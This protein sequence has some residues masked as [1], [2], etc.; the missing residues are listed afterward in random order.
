MK[1]LLTS[2]G[3]TNKTIAD[4][5]GKLLGKSFAQAKLAFIPTAADISSGD[6]SW[7]INDLN[8]CKKLGFREIDI[9]DIAAVPQEKIWRPRI[10]SADVLLFGG[11]NTFFLMH[12]L[13]KSGLAKLLPELLKSKVYVGISAGSISAAKNLALSSPGKRDLFELYYEEEDETKTDV[14]EGLGLVDFH[15]RPHLNSPDFPKLRDEYIKEIAKEVPEP[16]YAIDDQT[17]VQVVDGKIEIA[18]E[19]KYFAYNVKEK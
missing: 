14:N 17:A 13:K 1:L 18:S 9:I 11:G 12:C 5:L 7:L 19:G 16:I 4:A 6:K 3:I 15:V 10:E 8:N 2:G